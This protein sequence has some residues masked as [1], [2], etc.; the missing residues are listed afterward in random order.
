MA[1]STEQNSWEGVTILALA[2]GAKYPELV[3]AQWALESGWGK[4]APGNNFFG[5]K[6]AGQ[7]LDTIEVEGGE[8]VPVK[9]SFLTF[10]GLEQCV[11]YLVDHWYKDWEEYKG[12][13]RASS[14]EAAARE[15]QKQGYATNPQYAT[16]LIELMKQ[17]A[18]ETLTSKKET[19]VLV[20]LRAGQATWLKKEP[21]QA[22]ELKP[23]ELVQVVEGKVFE[24]LQY[25]ELA[26]DAHAWVKLG[27]QAGNW[28]I[29]GPH[30]QPVH[31][32]VE[33]PPENGKV[34]WADFN[35]LVTPNLTVGEVLQYDKRRAPKP[36]SADEKRILATAKA[37]Q[38]IR[39]AWRQ[40]LGVTSF[41]RPEPINEQVGGVQG[42]RHVT[43]EAMDVYPMNRSIES[44]YEWIRVRWTGGLG[45]GRPRGF[46]HLD[47]RSGGHFVPGAGV[48]PVT[49]WDY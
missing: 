30:W 27:H 14:R 36:G 28:F 41:Y 35:C 29:Y 44:F 26:G 6:G 23:D 37:F 11:E 8:A 48:R 25:K 33:A 46:I 5:L 20:W 32:E 2:A 42:S 34:N 10:S 38:V 45:D 7:L 12:V 13:N 43:G 17:H 18:G 21:K 4:H 3:A 40:P 47:T 1:R 22:V 15:L 49:Q 9:D 24:V 39:E 19:P 31:K 16:K